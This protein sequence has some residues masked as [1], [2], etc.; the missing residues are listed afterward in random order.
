MHASLHLFAYGLFS[1]FYQFLCFLIVWGAQF[2]NDYRVPL[3]YF[4]GVQYGGDQFGGDQFGGGGF[5][6]GFGAA[7]FGGGSQFAAGN[8][9]GDAAG[10]GFMQQPMAVD[11]SPG[12][13]KPKEKNRQSLI[14][15]TIKQLKNAP[16]SASGENGYTL[17]GRDLHQ[18]TFVGII[19]SADEQSTNL[20]YTVDDGT[21]QIMVKMW[22]DAD[23]DDALAERRAG[24]KE[25]VLVRVIGQLRSFNN[26]KN[27]VAYSINPIADFNEY[28]FHFLEVVHTHLRHTKGPPPAPAGAAPMAPIQGG[29]A[30]YAAPA[31]QQTGYGAA[32]AASDMSTLIL[33]FFQ[34][35]GEDSEQGSTVR[36]AAD[37]LAAN[38]ATLD[39]VRGVVETL[40]ADGHLYS[41]I[42]D[43]HFKATA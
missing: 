10:G 34:S 19:V 27:V 5:D 20:M 29:A 11:N 23:A 9:G 33:S 24:W 25:G 15:T 6:G 37:A 3:G 13:G 2:E 14:P 38:G 7:G 8:F 16:S 12:E 28:T 26:Q 17:D 40:V 18:V 35:K 36:E 1:L 39:Q 31:Q 32:P 30:G 42:D 21:D 22:V 4:N 41:T 43:D